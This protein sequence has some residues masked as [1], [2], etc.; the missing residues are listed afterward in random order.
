MTRKQP[1]APETTATM[2]P[3]TNAPRMKSYSSIV[4]MGVRFEEPVRGE[5]DDTT[6]YAHHI[7]RRAVEPRQHLAGDDFVDRTEAR[8]AAGEIEHAVHRSQ[9]RI[10]LVRGEEHRHALASL[11]A[12]HQLDD[13]LLEARVEAHQ[14]LVQQQKLR[15]AEERLR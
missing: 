5:H 3:A 14:R 1:T 4:T 8:P 13:V 12:F 11:D 10:D 15:P 7:D 2:P 6:V 9:Q